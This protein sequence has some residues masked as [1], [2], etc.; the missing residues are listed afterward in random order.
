MGTLA[1]LEID[2]SIHFCA[3][4]PNFSWLEWLDPAHE[5]L[6]SIENEVFPLAARMEGT[7]WIVPDVPGLGVEVD[8][9]W[10]IRA[11]DGFT[12]WEA[13]H[14]YRDDGSKTNW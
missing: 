7:S 14:L 13:P 10:L 1:V 8:E 12:F 6:G 9:D 4:V 3:A 11:S 5:G 2:E